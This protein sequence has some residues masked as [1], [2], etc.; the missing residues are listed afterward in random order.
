MSIQQFKQVNNIVGWLMFLIAT[1]VY[2]L[3]MEST[4][5]LWDCGEFIASAQKLQ[6]VHPPGAPL[7]LMIGR[8]FTLLAMGTPELVSLSMNFMSALCSGFAILFLFW[9]I[10]HMAR[11]MLWTDKSEGID[12]ERLIVILGAGIIGALVGTFC[13]SIWFSAVEGEVYSMSLL[14]TAI[15]FWA[16]LK[17][18]EIADKPYA[19]RWLLFIA[20][21]VGCSI[22]VHWLNLLTIPAMTFVYYFKRFKTSK[23]GILLTFLVSILLLGFILNGV[24]TGTISIIA[25]I[26]LFL[27][28]VVGLP[29]NSGVLVGI[30][31]IVGAVVSSLWFAYKKDKPAVFNAILGLMFILIGYMSITMTVIRSKANP[32]IDMNSPEDIVALDT[33]LKREQYGSR[34]FLTG[35]YYTSSVVGIEEIGDKYQKGK[36]GYDKV[37]KKIQYKYDGKKIFFPRL[38]DKSH[39]ARYERGLGLRKGEKPSF[40]DNIRFFL[41][42]QIGHMYVRYFM[43]NFVGR[44]NDEQGLWGSKTEGNWVS[45]IPFIDNIRLGGQS[46]LPPHVT[47]NP[48]RNTFYFIP[49]LLGL[50]GMVFQFTGNKKHAFVVLL[51]FL[52]CGV[53]IIVQGNSPPI[54]PR[55]RDY[56]FAGSFYAFAIWVGLGVVAL[57]DM[58]KPVLKN[59]KSAAIA[60][61]IIALL[62]PALMGFQGWD[63]HDRSSRFAARD[64]AS[65]YLNSCAPNA[66]IFT[67]GDNDTYPLW[68]AQEVEN[69]RR[70]VRVV[71]LSL[72]GVDWYINQLRRKVND[73]DPVPMTLTP[74]KIRGT[75]RDIVYFRENGRIAPKGEH[76]DLRKILEF[77][78]SDESN[79]KVPTGGKKSVDYYPT[80]QVKMKVDK[81]TVLAQGGVSPSNKSRIE[82]EIKWKVGKSNLY[83]NDLMVLDIINA[84]KWKRPIYFAISVS[85]DSYL[86]LQKYF[87]L[88][89]LAY[90]LVPVKA[91]KKSNSPFIGEV[92]PDIMYD[93]IANKFRFG[94]VNDP[95]VHVDSD[96]RRMIFNFRGNFSRLAETLIEKGDTKRAV[97]ILDLSLEKMPNTAAP[98]NIYMYSTIQNYYEARAFEKGNA[99]IK[100]VADRLFDD[101]K[102]YKTLSKSALKVVER[103]QQTAIQ[104]ISLFI[105]TAKE[106]G[107]NDLAKEL[108]GKLNNI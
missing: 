46:N 61:S 41:D 56:I 47:N 90:R 85:T 57:Y 95:S 14:C 19:D 9:I 32:N 11:R 87:Q 1:T 102:Y 49:L 50:L 5:S 28:N 51:L 8:V 89:G 44:Q 29:F 36:D 40:G 17:W 83:K 91:N 53:A 60:A 59:G 65:N 30:V 45:G 92:N 70:D 34:P 64:F 48:N 104:F 63:N 18:E 37:G 82:S 16:I 72:L 108:E 101:L 73:A 13:D 15:V 35:Y 23:K 78:A 25:T 54:E 67:Q 75:N 74:D 62:A 69:I 4:A 76:I 7:F 86:G 97:E 71:N 21:L 66:I 68:Y 96:L 105:N 94:N 24:I 107:Q 22:F 81:A 88:E 33:Y 100:K 10:T 84:N 99:L 42:Y 38:Y 2:T 55:E 106:K 39:Q 12:T 77:I 3:T 6:V 31:L 98:Y 79:T 20:F 27:V 103:D 43:W 93:N 80:R 52:F 58:L 26:E